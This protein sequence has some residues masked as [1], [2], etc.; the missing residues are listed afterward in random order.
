MC[1]HVRT[2]IRVNDPDMR[3]C[4]LLKYCGSQE[5]ARLAQRTPQPL[6]P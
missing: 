3:L 2:S 5:Y 4:D 1:T 6:T